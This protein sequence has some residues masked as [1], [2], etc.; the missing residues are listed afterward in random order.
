MSDSDSEPTDAF[1]SM[2]DSADPQIDKETAT[3]ISDAEPRTSDLTTKIEEL[4]AKIKNLEKELAENQAALGKA[5]IATPIRQK[6]L[7][8]F[9]EKEKDIFH[10]YGDVDYDERYMRY[11]RKLEGQTS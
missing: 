2:G 3:L 1:S 11:C 10:V 8:E 5:A 4:A 9:N 6:Q 7:A